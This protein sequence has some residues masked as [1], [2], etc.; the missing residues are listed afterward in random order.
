MHRRPGLMEFKIS[1]KHQHLLKSTAPKEK[2]PKANI[3]G[4]TRTVINGDF[5]SFSMEVLKGRSFIIGWLNAVIKIAIDIL[6]Y[7]EIPILC[8]YGTLRGN[9]PCT[10]SGKGP[11]PLNELYQAIYYVP[12]NGTNIARFPVGRY[13]AVYISVSTNFFEDFFRTHPQFREIYE[14]KCKR[15]E[16]G[17]VLPYFDLSINVTS[18]LEQIQKHQKEGEAMELFLDLSIRKLFY[19]YFITL[20]QS[21]KDE[22]IDIIKKEIDDNI[23]ADIKISTLTQKI[24]FQNGKKANR[25]FKARFGVT[26]KTYVRQ[27]IL[28][29]AECSL[30]HEKSKTIADIAAELGFTG[31]SYFTTFFKKWNGMTPSDF[32]NQSEML[33]E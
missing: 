20:V 4:A 16:E 7:T 14:S 21:E 19:N 2:D 32:R 31:Q 18:I 26:I 30:I 17:I 27:Q 6:P 9:V 5:G 23:G 25:E 11:V 33:T 10:L 29:R 12:A 22:W 13:E 24:A 8:W 1:P 28:L 15:S 3:K